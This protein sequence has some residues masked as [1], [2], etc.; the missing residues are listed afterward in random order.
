MR[1]RSKTVV[2]VACAAQAVI[3]A[4]TIAWV[5]ARG[6]GDVE[7]VAAEGTQSESIAGD[8]D[9]LNETGGSSYSGISIY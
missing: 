4:V 7:Q 8:D 6:S 9:I 1:D 2:L 3:V 5:A